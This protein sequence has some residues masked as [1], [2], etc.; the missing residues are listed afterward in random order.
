[1][2]PA[3]PFLVFRP[4]EIRAAVGFPD[5]VEPVA[6]ALAAFSGQDWEI[7]PESG[8]NHVEFYWRSTLPILRRVVEQG[9]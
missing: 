9:A 2:S 8:R 3:Q 5:L 6:R 7:G 1:M 4:H